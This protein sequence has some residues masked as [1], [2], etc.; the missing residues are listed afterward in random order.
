MQISVSQLAAYII[1]Q[2]TSLET[3]RCKLFL[4]WLYAHNSHKVYD[5]ESDLKCIQAA[6]IN[7]FE[8]LL[9]RDIREFNLVIG[10]V[11]WWRNLDDESLANI[12]VEDEKEDEFRDTVPQWRELKILAF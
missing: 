4:N 5:E 8:S 12:L 11:R 3:I 7:W 9:E 2:V 6:L 10:E 1:T